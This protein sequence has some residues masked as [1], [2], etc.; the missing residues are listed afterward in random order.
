MNNICYLL[1]AFSTMYDILTN[2]FFFT[3]QMYNMTRH[4]SVISV[5]KKYN[6]YMRYIN[7]IPVQ[8]H[9]TNMADKYTSAI[10]R[11]HDVINTHVNSIMER[12]DVKYIKSISDRVAQQV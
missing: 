3:E 11:L 8:K 12:D 4:P 1:K 10:Y 7:S 2:I 6:D 5:Q 9:L